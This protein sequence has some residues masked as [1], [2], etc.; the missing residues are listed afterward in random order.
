MTSLAAVLSPADLPWAELQA[1]R[2]D[3]DHGRLAAAAAYLVPLDG[4]QHLGNLGNH[5]P[6]AVARFQRLG[7]EE[8]TVGALDLGLEFWAEHWTNFQYRQRAAMIAR[9]SP[10]ASGVFR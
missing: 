7:F 10:P 5:Q 9:V 6:L 4:A 1:A 2:L 3:G 8:A